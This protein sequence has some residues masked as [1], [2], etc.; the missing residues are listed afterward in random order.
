[1]ENNYIHKNA[2]LG[3]NV[4]V[5]R[6]S[7]IDDNV[8]IG[9]NTIIYNNATILSGMR[10]GSNCKVFPG[11]VI[12]ADPQDISYRGEE[13]YAFIGNNV[14]VREC[15]TINRGTVVSGKTVIGDN[16]LL[17]AYVHVAHDCVVGNNCIFANSV[18]LG[19]HV[20]VG[21][22]AI[23][24]GLVGIHQ[25]VHIG[26]HSMIGAGTLLRKDVPPYVKAA[27]ESN[28]FEGVNSVGLRRRGFSPDDIAAIKK[29]YRILF[30]DHDNVSKAAKYIRDNVEDTP[31]KDEILS[32]IST[33]TRGM[34]K[35][36]RD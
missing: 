33:S 24:G 21:D 16:C 27:R 8:E 18:N 14:T 2:K 6:F 13:S 17:M 32:F 22:Y 1:M 36:I 7:Y 35:G 10:V 11:A 25:F 29:I 31:Y 28:S 19:G 4:Q 15:V 26:A 12:G 30:I 5:G 3:T 9:D 34:I 20:T 23:V